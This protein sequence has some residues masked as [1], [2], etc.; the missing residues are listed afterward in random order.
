M[1]IATKLGSSY[2]S[3]K[4]ATKQK[5]I[6]I[7]FN[8]VECEL[9][10]RVPFKREMEEIT[11]KISLPNEELVEAIYTIL[12]TPIKETVTN[13]GDGFIDAVNAEGDKLK[14]TDNDV[15]VDGTSVRQVATV[16]A[17]WQTQVEQYF[18][19]LLTESGEPVNETFDQISEEFPEYAIREIVAKIGDAI[20]PN[21]E[22]TKKN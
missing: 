14:I 21:Y 2:E 11:A 4:N 3:I 22:D 15:I 16:S 19:L 12:S 18:S 17:I 6:K 10:V 5:K 7:T 8:D 13:A 20:K 9:K 1:T